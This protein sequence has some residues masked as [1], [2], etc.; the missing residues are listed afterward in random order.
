MNVLVAGGAGYIG[1][2]VLRALQM[3]GHDCVA[4]DS[5]VKGHR[6]AVGDAKLIAA[7]VADADALTAALVENDIELVIHLA[8]F[9]EAGESVVKPGK[10][11]RNNTLNGLNLLECMREAGTKKLVFSST[12]AVYGTPERTPISETD[13]LQ[14]INPYGSSKLC[15]EYMMQAY[16]AAHDMGFVALRYFN[17]AG[18]HPEGGIGEDHSP[19]THLIPLILQVPLGKRDEIKIFGED[20]DTPDGTC[21][22]DYIHVCDLADAHV[23]A[24]DAIEPGQMKVYNLGNGAG[25]SVKEVIETCRK[26]TDCA[27]PAH[28]APRRPGDPA[29]LVA[30]SDKAIAELN[31]QRRFPDLETIVSHAWEWHR[32]NPDGYAD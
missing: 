21:I 32:S 4:Y 26:V 2:H 24:A 16:A 19:E 14:P 31:W 23:L 22:R 8:A 25:F 18:A 12:A 5:L 7:D 6:A 29:R 13:R 3:A 11:F 15:T 28:S 1:S 17:V 9:I 27:I 30:A 20:Y 10:Y